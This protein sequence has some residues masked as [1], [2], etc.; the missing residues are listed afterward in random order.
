MTKLAGQV[1]A[2]GVMAL[3]GLQLLWLPIG[4][5]FSL[6]PTEGVLLTVIIV[7]VTINAVNFV[8]GL[9]GLAAGIVAIAATAFFAYSYL[10]SVVQNIDRATSPTL[11]SA[12]LVGMCLGFLPHNFFPAKVFM[13][14]SGSMLIGLLLASTTISLTGQVP[15]QQSLPAVLP[16]F[17]PF[18]VILVP[19]STWSSRSYGAR[20]PG[21]RRSRRT[22]STC[23]TGCSS[24]ATRTGGRC[25]SSTPGRPPS[26]SR[27]R[28]RPSSTARALAVVVADP[29]GRRASWSA[30]S[31]PRGCVGRTGA[32]GRADSGLAA[33]LCYFS[34]APRGTLPGASQ[35]TQSPA[36]R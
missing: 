28:R 8:D 16:L 1:L 9:D 30:S 4:G 32:P 20:R 3:Q 35:T 29:G 17:L 25:W 36:P 7:V 18:A 34:Q 12:V 15:P 24:S 14:D 23:T 31:C 21:A 13:G 6:G 2:A 5:T 19:L 10:L 33:P 26:P 27:P 11:V 22:S